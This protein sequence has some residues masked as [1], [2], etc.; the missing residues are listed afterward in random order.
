MGWKERAWYLGTHTTF[1]GP[2]FD[3]N[4]NVGPT[5]W[6]DGEV[7]GAWGQRPDGE[8]AWR[9]FDDV[10]ASRAEH[11]HDAIAERA[12]SI[13]AFL[14]D[15]RVRPRFATPWQVELSAPPS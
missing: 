7:V 2:L 5:V 9:L 6:A 3:R 13:T 8:V 15:V 1:P 4:G 10:S 12:H 11:L 14:G